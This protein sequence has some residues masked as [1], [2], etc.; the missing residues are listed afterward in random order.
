MRA[1]DNVY[2]LRC[3]AC[4]ACGQPLQRGDEYVLQRN[5]LYCKLDG[6]RMQEQRQLQLQQEP[7][8]QQRQH[9]HSEEA[10]TCTQ[11]ARDLMTRV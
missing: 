6:E 1:M 10:G 2:H 11:V 8:Q 9:Q 4:V 5:Q 7:Q 3:F